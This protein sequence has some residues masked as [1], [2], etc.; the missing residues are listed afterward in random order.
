M[1]PKLTYRSRLKRILFFF[2]FQLLTLHLKRNHLLLLCWLVLFG[3]VTQNISVKYGLPNL[4]LYPE[5]FGK[6]NML[7]YA[8]VGFTFGGFITAFNL[9]S[10]IMHGF[11]FPFIATLSRPFLKFSL[12]NFII[13][14]LFLLLFAINSFEVQVQKEL[15][16]TGEALM[17]LLGAFMGCASFFLISN[18]Y[19]SRT[20]TDMR[21]F[22][23]T[24]R[25]ADDPMHDIGDSLLYRR[26]SPD[27]EAKRG[28]WHVETYLGHPFK[29]MLARS[30]D[31][32][33][34]T[35]IQRIL[36]QNHVN[37]SIFEVMLIISFLLF[38]GLSDMGLFA[39]PAA[40]SVVLLFTMLIMLIS[41]VFSWF[42][43]WT[44]TLL[45]G[46]FLLVNF[47]STRSDVLDIQS[48]VMGLDY[49]N[50]K[51]YFDKETLEALA[52][53]SIQ[54]EADVLHE[55]NGLESWKVN[56]Q[57]LH[58]GDKPKLI[59]LN[60]SGG[61][62]RSMLWTLRSVQYLDS[63]LNGSLMTR[64]RMITGSSG[65]MITATYL[66]E[67]HR[68][69]SWGVAVDFQDPAHEQRLTSE[70]LN[71]VAFSLAT[72]DVMFRYK[73]VRDGDK[74]YTRDRGFEFERR[75]VE[76]SEGVLGGRMLDAAEDVQEGIAPMIVLS[77]TVINDGR[78]LLIS[79][80]PLGYLSNNQAFGKVRNTSIVEDIEFN[81]FFAAQGAADL[82]MS[83]AL[84]MNATFPFILPVMSLPSEPTMQVMDAGL[85]DNYGMLT[86]M[87]YLHT[88]QRWISDNTSGV[89]IIQVRDKQKD[90]SIEGKENSLIS[91]LTTP[92]G[93]V[94]DNFVKVQDH[95]HDRLIQFADDMLKVPLEV[96]PFQLRHSGEEAITLSWRLTAL[97]KQRI[98][99]GV[100]SEEN[101]LA[102]ERLLE[103][104]TSPAPVMV[105]DSLSE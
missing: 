96:V 16:P 42:K 13:P 89:V 105:Q 84:R 78:R 54:I 55:Q 59:L 74:S 8:I 101:R 45:I 34:K 29:I 95:D 87:Q 7:S 86:T 39:I 85:R 64:T 31:H 68:S 60:V 100:Y 73:R 12:N 15:V 90:L 17:N 1:T 93:S 80:Q 2:P 98:M 65:G 102:G 50:G 40:A 9:Y 28:K 33:D 75:L 88:F 14:A 58:N 41:A 49:T 66:R 94:Y 71:T 47:L 43:G 91:R 69:K 4:F 25:P 52:Y 76:M 82:K 70:V 72:N 104:L 35:L 103:L 46:A 51:A 44:L 48:H 99:K 21:K 3:Y 30:I 37:G 11:R 10:Y 53:N 27:R 20:N 97:E 67:L 79:S 77:P 38:G 83:S 36:R 92:V 5:Y 62:M 81:R 61:G 22:E 19:F 23:N 24:A 56:T 32:Y 26:R 63:I 6:V 57:G 18:L